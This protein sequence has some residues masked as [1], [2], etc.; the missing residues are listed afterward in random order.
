LSA[1]SS[2]SD[3][4]KSH[5]EQSVPV[6]ILR[7]MAPV[8][9]RVKDLYKFDY[10]YA[11]PR[12]LLRGI[13][14]RELIRYA[15]SVD[16]DGIMGPQRAEAARTLRVRIQ[17]RADAMELGVEIVFVGLQ[18]FHPDQVVAKSFQDVVGAM[19][20]REAVEEQAKGDAIEMLAE[21]VGNADLALALAEAIQRV[22]ELER[23]EPS[24]SAALTEA[25]RRR[26]ELFDRA[27]GT[28]SAIIAQARAYRWNRENLWVSKAESFSKELLAYRAAP[29]VYSYR[30]YLLALA[31]GL[32]S[33]RKVLLAT[34][35]D[36][37]PLIMILDQQD[38]KK[39]RA[40]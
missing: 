28:V 2:D 19:Q 39:F 37:P 21:V 22:S 27:S 6:S 34:D 40:Q 12:T 8:Q 18:D 9:Y 30:L 35:I 20:E 5:S 15:A 36:G 31:D 10:H 23:N 25:I 11:N 3:P 4:A 24:D 14:D 13:A 7:A 1:F 33:V 32:K 38:E 26:D 17:N 29:S 16:V